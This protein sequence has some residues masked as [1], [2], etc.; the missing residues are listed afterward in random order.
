MRLVEDR[1]GFFTRVYR[2]AHRQQEN[3]TTEAFV[4]V[5]RV[6]IQR[7]PE[8][9]VR[10]LDWLTASRIFST[11]NARGPLTLRS[12]AYTEE[13]GIPDVRIE[14]EDMDVIIEVK[15]D[16]GLT[17]AQADAYARQLDAGG[18]ERTA[19]VALLGSAA[20]THLPARTVVRTWG[21]VGE[22]LQLE[23]E[24]S[25]DE[26]TA[27]VVDELVELLNHLCLMPRQVRSPLSQA[28]EAHEEWAKQDLSRPSVLRD[29]IGSIARLNE[30]E[31]CGPLKNLLLQM[32][33]VLQQHTTVENFQLDSG[34]RGPEA[35][36]GFNIDRM[37]YFFFVRLNEPEV[38]VL[39]R[40][41]H[42]VDPSGFDESLG[43]LLQPNSA[44]ITGWRGTLDLGHPDVG[45]F[46]AGQ[47]E[48]VGI[49][50]E[51]FRESFAYAQQLPAPGDSEPLRDGLL[52]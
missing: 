31:H 36:I 21:E 44:G 1:T 33:H 47:A 12:Q 22:Q 40:Y 13:F 43:R 38:V 5:L 45:Y 23:A 29:R 8:A 46:G 19:L 20:V 52:S 26:V 15:L 34:P 9:S 39:D 14:A 51:F 28:L 24:D 16:A 32:E 2:L 6:M 35:W 25:G 18:A 37:Q 41:K 30:M 7:A 10:F 49:L 42:A 4:H 17:Y 50:T 11:R 3:F 48:Q 27:Y